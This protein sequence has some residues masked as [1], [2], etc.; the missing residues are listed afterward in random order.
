MSIY[1]EDEEEEEDEGE[2]EE[3]EED[4]EEGEDGE[5]N[6]D[7]EDDADSEELEVERPKR[8]RTSSVAAKSSGGDLVHIEPAYAAMRPTS[9][10]LEF[11][12]APSTTPGTSG[13][14]T[15]SSV[16]TTGASTSGPIPTSGMIFFIKINLPLC[17]VQYFDSTKK[18]LF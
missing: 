10:S 9:S 13:G 8:A 12:L 17:G 3:E 5:S 1:V 6:E 11:R 18:Y 7:E 16:T 14:S 4:G 15:S 2:Y